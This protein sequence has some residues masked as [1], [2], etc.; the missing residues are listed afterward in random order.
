MRKYARIL[1]FLAPLILLS[2]AVARAHAAPP[3]AVAAP[4]IDPKALYNKAIHAYKAG[5]DNEAVDDLRSYLTSVPGDGT[6]RGLLGFLELKI[7]G[8]DALAVSDLQAAVHMVPNDRATRNNL[9][10]ALLRTGDVNGAI[11]QFQIVLNGAPGDKIAENNLAGAQA[12]GGQYASAS[13]LYTKLIAD[14]TATA[15]VYKNYGYCLGKLGQYDQAEKAYTQATKLDPTDAA[16]WV[17]TGLF[18]S[19]AGDNAVAIA[20][21]AKAITLGPTDPFQ[22]RFAYGES[23]A[24]SGQ[25]TEALVQFKYAA[26]L[27]PQDFSSFYNIGVIDAR[28]GN[29]A[30]AETAYNQALTIQ[31]GNPEATAGLTLLSVKPDGYAAASAQLEQVAKQFPHSGPVQAALGTLY[32]DQSRNDL[33][34][35]HWKN[36]LT[37][38]PWDDQTRLQLATHYVSVKNY[39]DAAFEYEYLSRRDPKNDAIHN[40]R[41]LSYEA[42]GNHKQAKSAFA[43]AVF[44]NPKNAAA[45]NNLGVTDEEMGDTLDATAEYKRALNADP[46]MVEAKQ[47]LSRIGSGTT[48]LVQPDK[49]ATH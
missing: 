2:C 11:A 25:V 36:A 3:V 6:A 32:S 35:Q 31:P 13:A 23:L 9:G 27:N 39:T 12:Q 37:I 41:G 17:G 38:N 7:G 20:D 40:A 33:A 18:A 14:G 30:D 4:T 29:A 46:S 49:G 22:A 42:L 21:L 45:W 1:V 24:K 15:N 19:R 48:S 5:Y 47:N 44:A 34:V 28:L 26:V 10:S 8:D 16:S 43:D